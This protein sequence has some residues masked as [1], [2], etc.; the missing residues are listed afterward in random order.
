MKLTALT[1]IAALAFALPTVVAHG[2]EPGK[3][4][5]GP[6]NGRLLTEVE[7]HVEFLVTPDKKVELRFVDDANKVVA[8][9]AQEITVTLGERAKP[10]KLTFAKEGDKLVSNAPIPEGNDYPTVVQIREKAGAKPVNARFNLNMTKCPTCAN[11][12]Y[13]CKCDHHADEDKKK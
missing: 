10:T 9:G 1:L 4:K 7:P 13:N 8:P 5:V 12:E 3:I 11:A 2:H 6:T